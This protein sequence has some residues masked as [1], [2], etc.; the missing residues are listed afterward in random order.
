MKRA[1]LG[2]VGLVV[3]LPVFLLGALVGWLYTTARIGYE[4]AATD[5]IQMAVGK[6]RERREAQATR[7]RVDEQ[8]R[9]LEALDREM[10]SRSST[11][12]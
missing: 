9:I 10:A 11:A 3:G 2:S 7:E 1:V 4:L 5:V 12:N 6:M 8:Q